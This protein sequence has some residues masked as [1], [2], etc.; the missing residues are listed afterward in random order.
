MLVA[1]TTMMSNIAMFLV[2]KKLIL[3]WG[4]Q[5]RNKHTRREIWMGKYRIL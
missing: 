3:L 2:S 5:M 1:G 4:R